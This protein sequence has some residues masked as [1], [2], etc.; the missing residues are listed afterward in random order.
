MIYDTHFGPRAISGYGIIG[1]HN[2]C[3]MPQLRGAYPKTK[4]ITG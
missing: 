2:S 1:G 3:L 4:V